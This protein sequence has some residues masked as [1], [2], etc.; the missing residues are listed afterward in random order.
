MIGC[1]CLPNDI[2]QSNK[3]NLRAVPRGL[4]HNPVADEECRI[5]LIEPASTKHPGD[6]ISEKPE[7]FKNK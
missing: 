7:A 6:V 3:A 4:M 5:I 1:R 2:Q